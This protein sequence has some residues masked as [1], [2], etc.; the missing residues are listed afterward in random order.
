VTDRPTCKCGR[1]KA[2][3]I[4]NKCGNCRTKSESLIVQRIRDGWSPEA[5]RR[6][7]RTKNERA[8]GWTLAKAFEAMDHPGD[9]ASVAVRS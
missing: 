7:Y 4:D 6:G 1:G 9:A 5:A 3:A 8:G 2:S